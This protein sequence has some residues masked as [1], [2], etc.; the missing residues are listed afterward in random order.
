MA[1]LCVS[2]NL[3]QTVDRAFKSQLNSLM[4][5]VFEAAEGADSISLASVQT[6]F[7]DFTLDEKVMQIMKESSKK[8]KP[9]STDSSLKC[10]AYVWGG[11]IPRS[12]S[13]KAT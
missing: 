2:K 1:D 3:L 9:K 7:D 10:C 11:G 4:E 5:L 13:F 8:S 12:C 6:I